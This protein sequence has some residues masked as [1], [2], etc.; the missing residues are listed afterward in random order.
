MVKILVGFAL[1]FLVVVS[2]HAAS[3]YY[4]PPADLAARDGYTLEK[5]VITDRDIPTYILYADRFAA[6]KKPVVILLHGGG[7]FDIRNPKKQIAKEEWFGIG[8]RGFDL[9]P[10]R[11]ADSAIMV[12]IIDMWWAGERY[13]PE[14]LDLIK[15]SAFWA[16]VTG[17]HESAD[18]VSRLI[19]YLETRDDADATRVGVAGWSGGGQTTLIATAIDARITAA[20]CWVGNADMVRFSYRKGFSPKMI[21]RMLD[22]IPGSREKLKRYDPVHAY[23][24]IPPIALAII[25]NRHDTAIPTELAQDL[26]DKLLPLYKDI[27]ERLR[28]DLRETS[29]PTHT[30]DPQGYLDGCDWL[31]RF[32]LANESAAR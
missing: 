21:E 31:I 24:A 1:A 30:L 5:V 4:P 13:N 17:Y 22:D 20:V 18:D 29:E 2:S 6:E 7:I 8:G 15:Q 11:L 19:D 3:P 28:L 16:V 12:L 23:A 27:P 25:N 9:V 32:L 10:Y 26:Y 14:H